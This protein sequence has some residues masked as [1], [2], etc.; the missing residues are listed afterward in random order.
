MVFRG[1][2]VLGIIL[3]TMIFS[4]VVTFAVTDFVDQFDL[5]K[6]VSLKNSSVQ[7]EKLGKAF[8]L[9]KSRYLHQVTDQQLIDGAI[10]GMV[11]ALKDPYSTY[12][13]QKTAADF[14]SDLRSSFSGIGAE[15]QMRNGKVTISTTIKESPAERAGLRPNDQILKVDGKSLDGLNL[16]EA[17]SKIRGPKGSKVK[18]DI[19]RPGSEGSV[20]FTLTRDDIKQD[21]VTSEVLDNNIGYIKIK[22]FS[23]NTRQE[24]VNQLSKLEGKKITGL[25]I[26]VRGNPGGLLESVQ[27]ILEEFIPAD[28]KILMTEDRDGNK[29]SFY[30]RANSFKPYPIGVLI[31][32][33]S[34]SA[35]EILAAGLNESANAFLLGERS[36]GKG[37]VQTAVDFEDGSNI[38]LTMGKWLTPKG[39]WIDQ[40]G[41]SKGIQPTDLVKYP[42]YMKAI[43][44]EPKQPLVKNNNSTLVKNMQIILQAL[45]YES[46]RVDG[47]FDDKTEQALKRFQQ[48]QKIPANGAFDQ[49]SAEHLRDAFVDMLNDLKKDVQIQAAV[50]KLQ[51]HK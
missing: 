32:N 37:T 12:M 30:G 9:I 16:N 35:A 17:V 36:F 48:A 50:Q 22:Q 11:R 41:G 8:K 39:N 34:A 4:S 18:L 31:D 5:T 6:D 33:G 44:P 21:T 7:N 25:L 38:K 29:E 51:K 27:Q 19:H 46:G 14:M 40:H 45:G 47:Y 49:V 15:V 43:F 26:D 10:D 20:E 13:D 1:K 2:V 28:K 24:F 42:E 3:V 23:E